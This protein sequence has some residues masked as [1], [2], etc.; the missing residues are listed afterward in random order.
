MINF[1][2]SGMLRAIGGTMKEHRT[3]TAIIFAGIGYIATAYLTARATKKAVKKV[4]ELEDNKRETLQGH[5][6]GEPE[7]PTR[8]EVIKETWHYYI[9]AIGMG[10]AATLM[11]VTAAASHE[12][13]NKAWM[14][15]YALSQ[16][17]AQEFYEAV[18]KRLGPEGMREVHRDIAEKRKEDIPNMGI[19]AKPSGIGPDGNEWIIEP[20]SNHMIYTNTDFLTIVVQRRLNLA[21]DNGESSTISD[22]L[23]ELGL[24]EWSC[25][26]I[27]YSDDYGWNQRIGR[28]SIGFD[29]VR[30][31]GKS[32][33]RIVLYN[34]PKKL[35]D[36]EKY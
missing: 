17:S 28:V 2:P 1:N 13:Q 22:Y 3:V 4:E 18:R 12:R 9:P 27:C 30:K 6:A 24:P 16:S 7:K 25:G 5:N 23:N 36:R 14:T 8:K 33:T 11:L 31:D 20:L 15:A 19:S 21:I 26:G 32:Y 10:T 34:P 29:S 35:F